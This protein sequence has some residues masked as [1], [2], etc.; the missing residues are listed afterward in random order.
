M[1]LTISAAAPM[2]QTMAF[3]SHPA[4]PQES[5][6]AIRDLE[7]FRLL[8]DRSVG[9]PVD[10]E[11]TITFVD[12]IWKFIFL[13]EGD[14]A[15]FVS[16]VSTNGVKAGD[17][18]RVVGDG[19][20]GDISALILAKTITRIGSGMALRPQPVSV[21]DLKLG[22]Y[23]C[24]LVS[25]KC[26]VERAVSSVG[27]TVFFCDDD[28]AKFHVVYLGSTPLDELWEKIGAEITV[29]GP[30]ALTLKQG[31]EKRD[32]GSPS[33][34]VKSF[35]ILASAPPEVHSAGQLS[36]LP[37][38]T[39]KGSEVEFDQH[40]FRL[41][42]QITYCDEDKFI[43]NDMPDTHLMYFEDNHSFDISNVVRV[44][45]IMESSKGGKVY[46]VLVVET[47]F[48][49]ALPAAID[50]QKINPESRVWKSVK[51][52]G[53]PINA[54]TDGE[55]VQFE[56]HCDAQIAT[57]RLKDDGDTSVG[58][59][60]NTRLLRV[61]GVVTECE[62][63]GD[64]TIV[65]PNASHVLPLAPAISIWKYVAWFLIPLTTLFL[66]GFFWVKR[67]RNRAAAQT[68]SINAINHRLVSTFK[69]IND[70][71]L[72]V[73]DNDRVLSVNSAF[74][75]IIERD[76]IPGEI[77]SAETFEDFLSQVKCRD[78]VEACLLKNNTMSG[79]NIEIEVGSP[80]L[81]TN[82]GTVELTVIPVVNPESNDGAGGDANE[83]GHEAGFVGRLLVLRD[84]TRE[85]Q[86]QAE[87]IR[88]NRIEAVG[89]L[90]GGIAHDFN[91]ILTTITANL[92]LLETNPQL[93]SVALDRVSDAEVA[94][95][96]GTDLVRRLLTY[97]GKTQLN[98]SPH[99][100][101]E[102]IRELYKFAGATFDA[103]YSFQFDL[104]ES[105][106]FVWGD[107]GSIEQVILNL[108]LNARDAMPDGG[109]IIS[110]TR[111]VADGGRSI[112]RIWIS[113]NGPGISAEIRKQ[114][115]DPF[116]TT[117]AG[118]AGTGLG[119]S[120]SQRL[121]KE[122]N[123]E[124]QLEPV[125][126]SNQQSGCCFVVSLPAIRSANEEQFPVANLGLS[127]FDQTDVAPAASD[128]GPKTILVVDDEDAIRKVCTLILESYGFNV[129]T[130][131]NG[132]N[133]LSMLETDNER[134]D[135]L[136]LD[137][138]MPG[139]SGLEVLET[140]SKIY[141]DLP[142][143]LFSGYLAGASDFV[144]DKHLKLAK[145]FSAAQLVGVIYRAINLKAASTRK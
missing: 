38:S 71:L 17:R 13:Q 1:M 140:T 131:I 27:H 57:I 21:S 141:P 75:A 133:A 47:L 40:V 80:L 34:T 134:I 143:I 104:D 31:S 103:R 87:L 115:F 41:N 18:V 70:G 65:A 126:V 74:C 2:S 93:D 132:E 42:G 3:L 78:V 19:G 33:R 29:Q 86:M 101:N 120:T 56:I 23:D 145:P 64:C 8:G 12:P 130:A 136:L 116:F 35:R 68:D 37:S 10:L 6:Q 59:L 117:K 106:P 32:F 36:D 114:I 107:A 73:D 98:P 94:A 128:R 46:N 61:N 123:G 124:L 96:R 43:L 83:N 99:S 9:K 26:N 129:E 112:V 49:T 11:G 84:R 90:V 50:F 91:N 137:L 66:A 139:I 81:S 72:A 24:E 63:N 82:W 109:V 7:T 62:P 89:Q 108:Y 88:A 119:L 77:I 135:V 15:V 113:D 111:L 125:E 76:L 118:H 30:L 127:S 144:D 85:R 52:V 44:G 58:L 20:R 14:H 45:G 92:S 48:T 79:E 121:I 122:Q 67:Q 110:K 100:I 102:T 55:T 22:D 97:S 39:D 54:R 53:R 60:R 28:G 105:D 4:L 95:N 69:A 142:V 5:S 138:T 51:A 16:N 25:V